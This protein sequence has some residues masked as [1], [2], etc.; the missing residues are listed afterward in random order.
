MPWE[1]A[2]NNLDFFYLMFD[3]SEVYGVLQVRSWSRH[4]LVLRCLQ[5]GL[6]SQRSHLFFYQ[7]Y[8][9]EQIEPV[10]RHFETIT[11]NWTSIPEGHMDQ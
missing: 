3:R 10:F 4:Q 8:L 1:A 5:K 7:L 9:R 6:L 2:I 11:K